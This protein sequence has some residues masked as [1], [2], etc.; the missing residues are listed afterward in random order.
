[1]ERNDGFR[2]DGNIAID[3]SLSEREMKQVVRG[4]KN[5]LFVGNERGG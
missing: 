1:V 3:T 5:H 4:R 2:G